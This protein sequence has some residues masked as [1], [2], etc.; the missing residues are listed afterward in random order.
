MIYVFPSQIFLLRRC[1][2]VGSFHLW[3]NA[4]R[5]VEKRR[6]CGTRSAWY[7]ARETTAMSRKNIC[8]NYSPTDVFMSTSRCLIVIIHT[9]LFCSPTFR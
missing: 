1:L 6:S 5:K 7:C 4:L 9:V 2:D 8:G 3:Q